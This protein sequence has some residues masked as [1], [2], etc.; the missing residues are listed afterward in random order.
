MDR[1]LEY[2]LASFTL[3]IFVISIIILV[4][5]GLLFAFNKLKESLGP[6]ASIMDTLKV[7]ALFLIDFLSMLVN[8][9]T[10][11]PR[12]IIGL[13]GPAAAKFLFGDDFDTSA[14]EAIAGGLRTDRGKTAME[15]IRKKNE[16]AAAEAALE[17]ERESN[18]GTGEGFDMSQLGAENADIMADLQAQGIQLPPIATSQQSTINSSNS[19]TTTIITERPSRAASALNHFSSAN[20]R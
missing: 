13:I 2:F 8:A 16:A 12:K 6:G 9:I 5:G 15:E 1:F 17:K 10:F 20:I 14:I 18:I 4:L 7:A 19:Q 3:S 11:I